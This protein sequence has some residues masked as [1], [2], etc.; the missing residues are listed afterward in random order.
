MNASFGAL[1]HVPASASSHPTLKQGNYMSAPLARRH[2]PIVGWSHGLHCKD[3]SAAYLAY[4]LSGTH[5]SVDFS[6][7][8]LKPGAQHGFRKTL[9]AHIPV[10]SVAVCGEDF[11]T[12]ETFEQCSQISSS[13]PYRRQATSCRHRE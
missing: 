7:V 4:S 5:R 2:T 3:F 8:I 13:I 9:D 11:D 12:T 1:R 10:I 6:T